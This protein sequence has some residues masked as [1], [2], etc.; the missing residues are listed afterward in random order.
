MI[1]WLLKRI[2]SRLKHRVIET[3]GLPYLTRWYLWPGAS[4]KDEDDVTP[5]ARLA[6][7]IHF[8]HRGDAD[9][10][11]HN[12]PWGL[13]ASLVLAG[14]Y[15]EERMVSTV[16]KGVQRIDWIRRIVRPW[17]INVIR[18][19]DFHRVELLRPDKGCWTIFV[20]GRNVK[21]WGFKT[22]DTGEFVPWQAY[23]M[24]R[25]WRKQTT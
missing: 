15:D 20:A 6:V 14:G 24:R 9:R 13:S 8:F 10:D 7:F 23:L 12:H 18:G 22:R 2:T 1:E 4:R 11:P 19:G 16:D 25:A 21:E 3:D 17:S 5:K